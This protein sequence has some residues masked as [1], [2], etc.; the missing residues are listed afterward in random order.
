MAVIRVD[1]TKLGAAWKRATPKIQKAM[2]DGLLS[3]VL[4][5]QRIVMEKSPV[6]TGLYQ[7]SWS[8]QIMGFGHVQLGNTAPHAP[9]IEFGAR[10]H[11]P[12]I[13][14][15]LFWAKRVLKDQSQPPNFSP[16]VWGLAKGVQKKIAREG[17][18]PKHVLTNSLPEI[19]ELVEREI[20][21]RLNAIV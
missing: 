1:I 7:S 18:K 17:Q 11:T 19:L 3:G 14:P 13:L 15:L 20:E 10:P 4:A 6:D 16:Q 5:G 21:E 2:H 12:A 8:T 9:I